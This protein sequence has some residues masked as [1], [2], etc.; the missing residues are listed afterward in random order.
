MIMPST[1]F[2]PP[3]IKGIIVHPDNP[4]KFDF[5][6]DSGDKKL[7]DAILRQEAMKLI[8]YFMASVT[9]PEEDV[10]VNLSPYEKDRIVPQEFGTTEMG[11]DLLS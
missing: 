2:T 11:K 5:I 6:I 7:D 8:K 9:L 10:W 3:L 1:A 4:L